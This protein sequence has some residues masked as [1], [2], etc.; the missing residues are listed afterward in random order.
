MSVSPVDRSPSPL[1]ASETPPPH[2]QTAVTSASTGVF[3][4]IFSNSDTLLF[5]PVTRKHSVSVSASSSVQMPP[6]P[7]PSII[8]CSSTS[9]LP[10][11]T[12]P[13]LVAQAPPLILTQTAGGTFLLPAAPSAGNAAPFLLTTQVR[14]PNAPAGM[15]PSFQTSAPPPGHGWCESRLA[16]RSDESEEEE[17]AAP[18]G[19]T[20]ATL[21]LVCR[22][23]FPG[24]DGDEPWRLSAAEPA[25]GS[26]GAAA[27]SD[28]AY[29]R[30]QHQ[31]MRKTVEIVD[32]VSADL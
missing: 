10:A 20:N 22:A 21:L 17:A 13:P 30:F 9:H 18:R 23:G 12:A 3:T 1:P 7:P 24:A 6:P 26:H 19:C 11:S 16:A 27:H 8:S 14:K 31:S 25:G 28:P 2:T 29:D 5:L 15:S 4:F 32:G